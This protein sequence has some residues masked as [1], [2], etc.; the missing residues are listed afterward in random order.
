MLDT[1]KVFLL[2]NFQGRKQTFE[3]KIGIANKKY[4]NKNNANDNVPHEPLHSSNSNVSASSHAPGPIHD[5]VRSFCPI[6]SQYVPL[7]LY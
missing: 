1:P 7:P 5:R 6:S 2:I 4:F 3:Q